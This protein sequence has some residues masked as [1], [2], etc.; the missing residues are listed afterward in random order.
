MQTAASW[1]TLLTP[2]THPTTYENSTFEF[3]STYRSDTP[4]LPSD[5]AKAFVGRHTQSVLF[6]ARLIL[7]AKFAD[8]SLAEGLGTRPTALANYIR[9]I[10]AIIM[11]VALNK[12]T[13]KSTDEKFS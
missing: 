7:S 13:N 4:S 6:D 5:F 1:D 2:L 11:I 3:Q 9:V 12:Y 10:I 8:R